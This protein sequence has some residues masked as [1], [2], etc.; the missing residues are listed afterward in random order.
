MLKGILSTLYLFV[1]CGIIRLILLV[2]YIMSSTLLGIRIDNFSVAEA[3]EKA[4]S[5]VS[6]GG[7]HLIFT[8]N[9]E[10]LVKT[11]DDNYFNE[12]LNRGAMNLCDG[13]GIQLFTKIRRI[14]G[15]DFMIE[16]CALA[17]Q[18]KYSI[19]LLGSGSDEVVSK[20]RENLLDKFPDLKI[21]GFDKG[22]TIY[23]NFQ[24]PISN[25]QSNNNDQ[26]PIKKINDAKPDI[27][28]VAFGM[29][30]QEKW[31]AE[32]LSK[33]PSVKIGMGVGGAFDYISGHTTRAPR[34][35]RKIGL[36][37]LYRVWKQPK[38]FSRIFNATIKFSYLVLRQ[39]Y[40]D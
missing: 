18:K 32:N 34:L 22:P 24:F 40:V 29:G 16:L 30:K 2:Y 36:E 7:Q 1:N 23:E 13:F 17:E 8:P 4:G 38:R 27:L 31:L 12:V 10:M 25:F 15:V 28:F 39:N 3:L 35:M 5:F 26:F 11:K 9:P 21:V 20:T 14:P 6:S 19:Y 33:M 37:W